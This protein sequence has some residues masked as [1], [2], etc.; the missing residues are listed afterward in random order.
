MTNL[1]WLFFDDIAGITPFGVMCFFPLAEYSRFSVKKTAWAT[2]LVVLVVSLADVGVDAY[3]CTVIDDEVR[4]YYIANIMYMAAVIL[5]FM[6]YLYAIKTIWQRKIFIFLLALVAALFSTSIAN[7]VFTLLPAC[8]EP[9][10]YA[11]AVTVAVSLI[12]SGV[13]VPLMCLFLKVMYMPV[14]RLIGKK[15]F[16]YLNIPLFIL[17]VFYYFVFTFMPFKA[18]SANP[19]LTM[20]YFG[21]LLMV[22]MLYCVIFRMFRLISDRQAANER[23]VQAQHQIDIRD[24]QYRRISD[25]IE[26]VRR[27]RHDLRLHMIALHSFLK[28]GETDRAIEYLGQYLENFQ[29]QKLVKYSE[30]TVVNILVS[31]YADIAKGGDIAF[32]AH[33]QIP[34]DL[35]VQDTD[36]SVILGNLLENAICAAAKL[37]APVRAV[38]LNMIHKGNMLA[39]TVDNSFNGEILQKDGAYL[40]T[41]PGHRGLGLSSITDIAGK[42]HGGVEFR[43]DKRMFYSSVMLMLD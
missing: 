4:R 43:N 7:Y 32:S 39:V 9:G 38:K 8:E 12:I 37:P 5:C 14:D 11:N 31:H 1:L 17:F 34:G 23:Y 15:E 28:N 22:F 33:I 3:L 16:L 19:S 25:N 40:S 2:A 36:I 24:E 27:Q 21:L 30:N 35:P 13:F 29:E 10:L 41:K 26:N 6:W 20:L 18:L 42:Y